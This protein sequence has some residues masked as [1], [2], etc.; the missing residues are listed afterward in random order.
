[1]CDLKWYRC[2]DIAWHW[3]YVAFTKCATETPGSAVSKDDIHHNVWRP[4]LIHTGSNSKSVMS[5]CMNE[6]LP[7]PR[8]QS[9]FIELEQEHNK[10]QHNHLCAQQRHKSSW[11][12]VRLKK[13]WVLGYP[14]RH[15]RDSDQSSQG[16]CVILSVLSC[17]DS[18]HR[19]VL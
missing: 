5:K 17:C 2:V 14:L 3:K 12:S 6:S 13:L 1:M 15:S 8:K 19:F 11:A 16:A 10:I 18:V 4:C 9:Q 7:L